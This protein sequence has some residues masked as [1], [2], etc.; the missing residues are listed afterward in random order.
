MRFI[1]IALEQHADKRSHEGNSQPKF[2]GDIRT[3]ALAAFLCGISNNK[4]K[5]GLQLVVYADISFVR[6]QMQVFVTNLSVSSKWK[7]LCAEAWVLSAHEA[8]AA[9]EWGWN[10]QDYRVSTEL[11]TGWFAD[12]TAQVKLEW[13]KVPLSVRSVAE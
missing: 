11:V 6:P 13:P 7:Q 3:P 12:P 9:L 8:V 4:K 1:S 10:C 5:G 2:L